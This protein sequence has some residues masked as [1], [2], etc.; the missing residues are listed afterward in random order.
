MT[1]LVTGSSGHLGEA[2]VHLLRDR[3]SDVV[4]MDMTPSPRTDIVGSIC[5]RA[6]VRDT[7]R[8]IDAIIHTAT[9]HKPHVATHGRQDFVD[10]NVTGTLNLLEEAA[11]ACIGSLV[12]TST[13]SVFGDAL[14]PLPGQPAAWITEDVAPAPKNIYGI[15]KLAAENMCR[16][17]ARKHGLHTT[18]LRT[19]RFFP[20]EDD[21]RSVRE[22]FA[23]DNVKANE[24]L[25]RRVDIEDAAMAH[26]CA[27]DRPAKPGFEL[28]VISATTPFLQE[29]LPQL[30]TDAP[31]VLLRRLPDLAAEYVRR[32]WTMFPQIDR[33]YVNALARNRL[34]WK[35][36][37]DHRHVLERLR[38][39]EPVLGPMAQMVG[40]KGYHAET[41]R[42]GPYPVDESV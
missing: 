24:F 5:E 2:I 38:A 13:T 26:L 3:G 21:R 15:T 37:F 7:V 10:T 41:F 27:V 31:G 6:L 28:Y 17:F 42:D 19:S 39:D 34:G 22:A 4:G 25:F 29:D 18:V 32:G 16:L 14:V 23:D 9:L 8:G 40:K 33:V 11:D 36:R 35:P 12:F 1:I 20:E 30:R